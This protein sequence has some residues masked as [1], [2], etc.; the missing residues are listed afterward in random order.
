MAA[1]NTRG[2]PWMSFELLLSYLHTIKM[3]NPGTVT[4]LVV[5]E[6]QKLKY[7]FVALG[8]CIEGFKAIRKVIAVDGTFLKMKYKGV[9]SLLPQHKMVTT[10]NIL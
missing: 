4:H 1:S 5:D 6:D 2:A 8:A 7:L 3:L 10:N 9:R